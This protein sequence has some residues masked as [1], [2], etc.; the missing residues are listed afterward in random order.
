MLN[1]EVLLPNG[2]PPAAAQTGKGWNSNNN[3]PG[4]ST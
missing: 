2:L 4:V 3:I 1:K